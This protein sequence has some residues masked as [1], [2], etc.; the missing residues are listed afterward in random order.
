[1]ADLHFWLLVEF[2]ILANLAFAGA[3]LFYWAKPMS[4]R[5]NAWTTTLRERYPTFSK[6]P[7]PDR[8]LLNYRIMVALFRVAGAFLFADAAYYL[9]HLINRISR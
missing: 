1:M 8:A 3:A 5:Y 6:P 4:H 7:T 9:L 2:L